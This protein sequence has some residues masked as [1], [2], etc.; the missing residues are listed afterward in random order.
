MPG[1]LCRRRST[2]DRSRYL[3]SHFVFRFSFF[4]FFFYS[5]VIRLL[6]LTV[7]LRLLGSG[8]PPFLVTPRSPRSLATKRASSVASCFSRVR[9]DAL[10]PSLS[11]ARQPPLAHKREWGVGLADA[12]ASLFT[13]TG[14]VRFSFSFLTFFSFLAFFFIS[15]FTDVASTQGTHH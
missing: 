14:P 11:G 1:P 4:F 13:L 7:P 9:A 15:L 2:F 12:A 3:F 5:L 8:P 10:P 6:L